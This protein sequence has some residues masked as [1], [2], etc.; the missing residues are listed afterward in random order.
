MPDAKVYIGTKLVRAFRQQHADGRDGYAV[1][2][3][4]GYESWSPK[5]TFEHAYRELERRRERDD[6]SALIARAV[7]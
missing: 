7:L 6:E 4:D 2:Y 1:I 3:S 5:A